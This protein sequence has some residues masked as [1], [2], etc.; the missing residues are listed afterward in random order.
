[1]RRSLRLAR[2]RSILCPVDFSAQSGDAIRQAA[3]VAA[4]AAGV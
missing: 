3:H 1:M 4:V 2:F